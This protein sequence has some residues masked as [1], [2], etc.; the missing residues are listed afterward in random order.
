MTGALLPFLFDITS[1]TDWREWLEEQRVAQHGAR[2]IVIVLDVLG[3]GFMFRRVIG[4][5]FGRR[6]TR[7]AASRGDDRL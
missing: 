3:A 5:V 6:I 4:R 2:L 1:R 7:A